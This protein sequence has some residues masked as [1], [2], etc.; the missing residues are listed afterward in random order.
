[1]KEG[2]FSKGLACRASAGDDSIRKNRSGRGVRA[3]A[4]LASQPAGA[5][6]LA[7]LQENPGLELLAAGIL[8]VVSCCRKS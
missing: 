6:R 7:L 4:W 3:V 5:E 8:L 2:D 1:M